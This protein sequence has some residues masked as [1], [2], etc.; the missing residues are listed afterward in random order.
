ME[1][2][3]N[4]LQYCLLDKLCRPLKALRGERGLWSLMWKYFSK[5]GPDGPGWESRACLSLPQNVGRLL[6]C[7][8]GCTLTHYLHVCCGCVCTSV[9]ETFLI[10][11]MNQENGPNLPF[12]SSILKLSV[13]ELASPQK[14]FGKFLARP[15]AC[16]V[17][18][19]C[20]Q[21]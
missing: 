19:V 12:S 14:T 18:D 8:R 11:G 15:L 3:Q 21:L 20:G 6:F 13:W 1:I 17:N 4:L 5:P 10:E 16:F 9:H 2:L 7:E